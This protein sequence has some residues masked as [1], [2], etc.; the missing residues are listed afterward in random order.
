MRPY[1]LIA[2]VRLFL[3]REDH[4]GPPTL[5]IYQ[6]VDS[7]RFELRIRKFEAI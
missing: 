1:Q 6:D 2:E 5:H 4:K 3:I 7:V